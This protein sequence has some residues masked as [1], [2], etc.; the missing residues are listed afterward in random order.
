M[1]HISRISP[2]YKNVNTSLF[3]LSLLDRHSFLMDKTIIKKE[4]GYHADL[5]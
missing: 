1:I 2:L 5:A 4:R 3:F